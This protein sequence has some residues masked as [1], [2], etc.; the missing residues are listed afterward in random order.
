MVIIKTGREELNNIGY[1]ENVMDAQRWLFE[2]KFFQVD[3]SYFD[4]DGF[5]ATY[6]CIPYIRDA[7]KFFIDDEICEEVLLWL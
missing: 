2:N 7:E 3:G 5:E 1:A 4:K 6:E